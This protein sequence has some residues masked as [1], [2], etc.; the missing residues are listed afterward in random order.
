MI[1]GFGRTIDYVRISVTDRCNLRC[2]YCMPEEGVEFVPHEDILTYEEIVRICRAL[3]SLGIRKV[4]VTGGEPLLRKEIEILIRE[5]KRID[6]IQEITMTTN[7]CL[8]EE[9]ALS[10][11]Q[12]GLSSV[13]VSL[14]ALNP[15]RFAEIARREGLEAVLKGIESACSSGLKVKINCAV[16]ETL[17]VE[18]ML[19]FARFSVD[20]GIAVRFIEI[21]PI[22]C[23]NACKTEGNGPVLRF[24]QE[25]FDGFRK[26]EKVHGNGPAI[27]YTWGN[28]QGCLGFIN[29][30]SHCFC[31]SCN[32]IRLTSGGF[33]KL[34]LDGSEGLDVKELL[35][36]GISND[37]L[38]SLLEQGIKKKPQGH[39]F[40]EI[41]R[42]TRGNM[43]QIGG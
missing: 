15:K 13:N 41:Q 39:H 20:Y 26:D 23:A 18:E 40:K 38:V 2:V 11:K 35:R 34:C 33:L 22:G 5:L 9:K 21:M 17:Q 24:F 29:G 6:G 14:D 25:H 31:S 3:A 30:V 42:E 12:A 1:D 10:L 27:Y 28:G 4:K 32:R 16:W 37:G 19:A 7:G 36:A 8:L 43:N